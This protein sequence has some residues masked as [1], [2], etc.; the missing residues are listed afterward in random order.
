MEREDEQE[1]EGHSY[2]SFMK[3]KHV[4]LLARKAAVILCL[5]NGLSDDNDFEEPIYYL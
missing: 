3:S 4:T 1:G 5:S 2:R